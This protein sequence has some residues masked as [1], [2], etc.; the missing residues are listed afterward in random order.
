MRVLNQPTM[1][2]GDADDDSFDFAEDFFTDEEI[3]ASYY[4][5]KQ[6]LFD[7]HDDARRR[8][9]DLIADAGGQY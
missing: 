7:D 6:T 5:D 8:I 3:N 2:A 1:S 4:L 9:N